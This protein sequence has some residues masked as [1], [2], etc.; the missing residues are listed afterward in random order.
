MKPR[1]YWNIENLDPKDQTH[2]LTLILGDMY[3]ILTNG[4]LPQD[5]W[6]GQLISMQFTVA[7]TD[8]V[9]SHTLGY[10]PANYIVFN[11]DAAMI[12]YGLAASNTRLTIKSS[13]VGNASVFVF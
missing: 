12:I 13:A 3:N 8:T 9:F 10:A 1:N 5:N 6:R 11:L 4:I 7:N 2:Y